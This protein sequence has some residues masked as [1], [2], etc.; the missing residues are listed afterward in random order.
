MEICC[1][2]QE[3]PTGALYQPRGVGWGGRWEGGP[4]GRVYMY[5]YSW[6]MLRFDRKQPNS[7]KQLSFNKKNK[8]K[9]KNKS[10]IKVAEKLKEKKTRSVFSQN[11]NSKKTLKSKLLLNQ[12]IA[13]N[14]GMSQYLTVKSEVYMVSGNLIN[15]IGIVH[16][17]PQF[18]CR[19]ILLLCMKHKTLANSVSR[20]LQKFRNTNNID[21]L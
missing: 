14:L 18:L 10:I 8:L 15:P 2:A 12:Q 13:W 9:N 6:L 20:T 7:V 16:K 17:I 5:I 11:K 1:M 21:Q 19:D 4:K 3:T